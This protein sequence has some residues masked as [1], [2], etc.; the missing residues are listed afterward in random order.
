M[1]KMSGEQNVPRVAGEGIDNPAG[2][3]GGLQ[4]ARRGECREG[5]AT[6]PVRLGSLTRAK[7]AAVPHDIGLRAELRSLLREHVHLYAAA[8]RQRAHRIHV[9]ANGV[10][11]MREEQHGVI[12]DGP[13]RLSL[14]RFENE[15]VQHGCVA[16][17]RAQLYR[18]E[19]AKTFVYRFDLRN[20]LVAAS[21]EVRQFSRLAQEA[22]LD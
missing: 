17:L 22:S 6:L 15:A 9:R 3:I 10:T 13:S 11:M 4:P 1:R 5:I 8:I 20:R 18:F 12:A 2:G 14:A 7:L 21:I 16:E 19:A